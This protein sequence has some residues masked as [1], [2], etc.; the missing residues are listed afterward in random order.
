MPPSFEHLRERLLRAGIG[1]RHVTRYLRELS[2]HYDDAVRNEEQRGAPLVEAERLALARMGEDDALVQVVLARPE[3]RAFSAR[4]PWA[5][6]GLGSLAAFAATL[7]AA[8]LLNI[9]FLT[10]AAVIFIS[11][12]TSPDLPSWITVSMAG[13]SIFATHGLPLLI[14]AG[15]VVSAVRQRMPAFWPV[16]GIAVVS[17]LGSLTN[18]GFT[19]GP[20]GHRHLNVGLG[21]SGASP[22]LEHTMVHMAGN[23]IVLLALYAVAMRQI[24]RRVSDRPGSVV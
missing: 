1:P 8:A 20:P 6:Y 18:F 14:G 7:A 15:I 2:E 16:V 21:I 9:L 5:V 23:L 3:L 24:A 4:Y 13:F 11:L 12:Q 22:M 17:I 10:V 19:P